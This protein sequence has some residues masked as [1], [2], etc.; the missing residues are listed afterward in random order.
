MKEKNLFQKLFYI[1]PLLLVA[2]SLFYLSILFLFDSEIKA[3]KREKSLSLALNLSQNAIFAILDGNLS[4]L[5]QLTDTIIK[6]NNVVAAQVRNS[7]GKILIS[8]Y[9]PKYK[10]FISKNYKITSFTKLQNKDYNQIKAFHKK[11]EILRTDTTIKF[12]DKNISKQD[13]NKSYGYISLY[14]IIDKNNIRTQTKSI[15]LILCAS[16]LGLVTLI[17]FW[18]FSFFIIPLRKINRAALEL[19]HK[20]YKFRIPEKSKHHEE[21]AALYHRINRI[22]QM[23]ETK[24]KKYDKTKQQLMRLQLDIDNIIKKHTSKINK[25]SNSIKEAQNEL[26]HLSAMSLSNEIK[27]QIIES[28][29]NPITNSMLIIQDKL[30]KMLMI[31]KGELL[32]E[33]HSVLNKWNKLFRDG[34]L[35]SYFAS[36]KESDQQLMVQ[37]FNKIFNSIGQINENNETVLR[38]FFIFE[39]EFSRFV[40]VINDLKSN[41]INTKNIRKIS[42]KDTLKNVI[43]ILEQKINDSRIKIS[44]TYPENEPI[45]HADKNDIIYVFY[46][47][48]LNSIDAFRTKPLMDHKIKIEIKNSNPKYTEIIFED[49][50]PGINEK[51]TKN[52]FDAGFAGNG[53][54]LGYGLCVSSNIINYYN[55]SISL[56][57]SEKNVSTVF[58]VK[59]PKKAK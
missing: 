43:T 58:S 44:T 37:E 56:L 17:I 57:K 3:N 40:Q 51:D 59:I 1:M 27:S 5:Q 16:L 47:I 42:L 34:K 26:M 22:A 38:F 53:Q 11:K 24:E 18:A 25:S 30:P 31:K 23:L 32:N 49:N 41:I 50:G 33:L 14:T 29:A 2:F 13:N 7:V 20:H 8:S 6:N 52:I 12:I 4:H 45:I 15:V 10:N 19:K 54:S 28:T 35:D 48:I 55:G 39:K 9:V 21:F 46:N 36:K